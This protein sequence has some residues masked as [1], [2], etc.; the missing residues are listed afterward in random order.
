VIGREF[1]FNQLSALIDDTS[2]DQL[3]DLLDEALTARV[4]EELLDTAGRYQFTHALIQETL[5]IELSLTRRTR[6]HARIANSLEKLY[7]VEAEAHASELAHH[8]AQ[9]ETVLGTDK[10]V[11]Y[12]I[13]AGERALGSNAHKDALVHFQRALAAV[14]GSSSSIDA[15]HGVDAQEA[16][17]LFGLARAQLATFATAQAQKAFDTLRRAFDAYVELEDTK[18]AIAVATHPHGFLAYSSGAGEMAARA[19]ELAQ[20]ESLEA[21]YILSQYGHAQ[22]FENNDYQGAQECLDQAIEIARRERDPVLEVRALYP[23]AR[24]HHLQGDYAKAVENIR[25]VIELAQSLDELHTLALARSVCSAGLIT[26]GDGIEAQVHATAGLEAAERSHNSGLL[27][28]LLRTNASLAILRGDWKAAQEFIARGLAESPEYAPHLASG[29][30]LNLQL[31]NLDESDDYVN[32]ILDIVPNALVGAGY[33]HAIAASI[34][35]LFARVTETTHR[36]DVAQSAAREILSSPSSPNFIVNPARAGLALIAIQRGD[37]AS[38]KEQYTHLMSE[39][40]NLIYLLDLSADRILGILAHTIGNLNDSQAHFEDALTFCRKA[41][42][43]P[44][45]AWSLC[46]YADVLLERD[47]NGDREAARSLLDES[48]VL[49][50]DMGMRPLTDRV[51]ERIDGLDSQTPTAPAYPNGL[52][53]REVEV[54]RLIASGNTDRGIA[55][56]LVISPRTVNSHV[57]SIFNKTASANRTEAAL[58]ATRQGLA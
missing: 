2:Q 44:E 6:L 30:W 23:S 47:G 31:G 24:I 10:M 7:G 50:T 20:P 40:G 38:A 25:K 45:L 18:N 53:E 39:R 13:V 32:K 8:F 41:G 28:I 12:S 4:I 26:M 37:A 16:A 9:A 5:A 11:Q 1:G 48:L 55:D 34:V 54:L 33:Q 36:I 46:D 43:Q 42:Y 58:C 51:I 19:L 29:A 49:S 52:T 22:L 56:E 35:P 57:R 3:L 17:I 21:G 14:Q 27:V 15:G